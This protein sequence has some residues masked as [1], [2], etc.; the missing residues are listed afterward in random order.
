MDPVLLDVLAAAYAAAG[1]FDKAIAAAQ[2]ARSL[3]PDASAIRERLAFY[4]QR[5]P[6]VDV[7]GTGPVRL[8]R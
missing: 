6:Y 4:Q 3:V 1:S 2:A 5:R 8:R 7:L